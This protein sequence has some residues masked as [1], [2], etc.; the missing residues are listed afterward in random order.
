[1]LR[2]ELLRETAAPAED[3][4][5]DLGIAQESHCVEHIKS[6][7][8]CSAGVEKESGEGGP[9]GNAGHTTLPELVELLCECTHC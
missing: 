4:L 9:R 1:M 5:L 6:G 2:Q 8:T 7:V 3:L